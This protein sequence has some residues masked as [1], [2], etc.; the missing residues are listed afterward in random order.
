MT[1]RHKLMFG[2]AAG[3]VLVGLVAAVGGWL[4]I[5]RQREKAARAAY[6]EYQA[7]VGEVRGARAAFRAVNAEK[8]DLDLHPDKFPTDRAA[9]I[10][11]RYDAASLAWEQAARRTDEFEEGWKGRWAS[12]GLPVIDR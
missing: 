8:V 3:L 11:R 12:L 6:V 7:M 2:G 1:D 9:D 5:D 4:V 10:G